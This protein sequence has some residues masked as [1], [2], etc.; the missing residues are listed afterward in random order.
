MFN[1][2]RF[3]RRRR[4][5]ILLVTLTLALLPAT[6]AFASL[7]TISTTDNSVDEWFNQGVPLFQPDPVGD[8]SGG[9]PDEDIINTWVAAED[10]NGDSSGDTLNFLVEVNGSPALSTNTYSRIVAASIDCNDNGIH[11]EAGDRLVLYNPASNTSGGDFVEI[12]NGIQTIR[13]G[14]GGDFGQRVDQYLEWGVNVANLRLDSSDP[15]YCAGDVGILFATV[16]LQNGQPVDQTEPVPWRG[17]NV[18][19]AVSTYSISALGNSNG[20]VLAVVAF[21]LL[22]L[23]SFVSLALWQQRR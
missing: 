3:L 2:Q 12:R 9:V 13:L 22:L 4:T 19:T 5:V 1:L 17:I 20:L 10:S 7:Y 23:G 11:Q 15:D 18:P 14:L 21:G 6:A 16:S 8:D